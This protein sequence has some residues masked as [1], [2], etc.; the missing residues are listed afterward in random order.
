MR[1]LCD[2]T[3]YTC[4]WKSI[5]KSSFALSIHFNKNLQIWGLF[6]DKTNHLLTP[7]NLHSPV[8]VSGINTPD[9]T[10]WGVNCLR[11][12]LH[13][14][15]LKQIV[16]HI[17]WWI[18]RNVCLREVLWIFSCWLHR[19]HWETYRESDCGITT[20]E[21]TL[22]GRLWKKR[23]AFLMNFTRWSPQI[24]KAVKKKTLK[25]TC[26]HHTVCLY[27]RGA[28]TLHS[29]QPKKKIGLSQ[30]WPYVTMETNRKQVSFKEHARKG[31]HYT[32]QTL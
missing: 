12:W 32:T 8:N 6:V 13:S 7:Q 27:M 14:W 23:K 9:F 19:S 11:W 24:D 21:A 16:N 10:A 30:L 15:A 3:D 25:T 29:V 26:S 22:L 5:S 28:Q 18:Q 2:Y 4:D 31:V 20:L 1:R 17:T